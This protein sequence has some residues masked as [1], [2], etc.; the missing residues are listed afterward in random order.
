MDLVTKNLVSSFKDEESLPDDIDD[1]TL[2]E[3]FANFC[4]VSQDYGEEFDVDDVHTGGGD[5]LGIDGIAIVV[6]GAMVSDASEVE[7]LA[8]TNKYLEAEFIFCQAKSGGNFSGS[9]VSNLFFGVKDLFSETPALP[10]NDT[11]NEKAAVIKAIYERSA[12]FKRGNPL[13]RM[14]YVTTGKWQSDPKLEGRIEN[15]KE[16]VLELNIFREVELIPVDA[17]LL[18]RLYNSAKNRL[19]KSITFSGKVTLPSL[20]GVQ[21][22]YLGY[23]P[24]E[25]YLK[26]ITDDSGNIVRGLFYDNVRDFQG[27]NPVNHEI[28]ETLKSPARQLFVLLNNG[29]TIVADSISKTGDTFTI[30]DYQIVNGCQTSHV[31]FNNAGG[32]TGPVQIPVKLFVFS[33]R[34]CKEPDH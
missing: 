21:E 27:E 12:L 8:T 33:R 13:V 16:A 10:R 19:S 2:F 34:G 28:G 23:L 32:L 31:L 25:E 5:D 6:N 20:P 17:R 24:A 4:V 29:V 1:A 9:E 30:E 26:L 18:Q 15:E 7:D 22:S 14:Y 3:H 11:I